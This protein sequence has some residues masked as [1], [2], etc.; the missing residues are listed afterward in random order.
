MKKSLILFLAL[1]FLLAACTPSNGL[2]LR[3][4]EV[5]SKKIAEGDG[6]CGADPG[7]NLEIGSYTLEN[8]MNGKVVDEVFLG[9][10]TLVSGKPHDDL[11]K[12]P[13][14]LEGQDIYSLAQYESCNSE[15]LRLFRVDEEGQIQSLPFVRAGQSS[16]WVSTNY[17]GMLQFE[18]GRFTFCPYDQVSGAER[19]SSYEYREEEVHYVNP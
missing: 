5:Q 13:F 1:G 7:S 17:L 4:V 19:C 8:R 15:A 18:D 12:L 9:E 16:D 11:H 10:L 6:Y 3:G 2:F 14:Q